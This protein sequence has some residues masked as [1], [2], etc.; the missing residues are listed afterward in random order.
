MYVYIYIYIYVF[1]ILSIRMNES[2]GM[3]EYLFGPTR[4]MTKRLEQHLVQYILGME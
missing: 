3:N 1:D 4:L 2:K